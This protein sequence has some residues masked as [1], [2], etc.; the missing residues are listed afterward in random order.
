MRLVVFGLT[1]SSSWGNGHA[2]LWR[3]LARALARA[4]HHLEFF[5]RDE[6]WYAAHRDLA[7]LPGGTL[8]LYRDLDEVL[9]RARRALAGADAAMVT[10][11]CPDGARLGEEVAG[12]GARA[13][14]FY[15]L[16]TPVTR[17]R[18][19]DGDGIPW[20]GPGG[21]AA[22]D[23]VLSFTGG[24]SLA[25]LAEALGA[26]RAVPLH[27]WV[28]PEVHHPAPP[29]PAFAGDLSYLGTFAASRQ[30]G[31][32]ALFLGPAALLPRR[33]FVLAGALY[34]ERFP[35]RENVRWVRHLA[36]ARHPAFFCSSPLTLSVTRAE[37]AEDGYCPSGRLFEAAACGVPVLTDPWP[38]LEAFFAPGD[39]ILVARTAAEAAAA[40][41]TSRGEL[42]RIG[43]RARARA[44]AEHTAEARAAELVRILEGA[45]GRAG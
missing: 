42:A 17:A 25:F 37:M 23:V 35:W 32:E 40:V 7:E 12:S 11:F 8:H 39:E 16:D 36:P 30:E 10:S 38:G 9:P 44:L 14:A 18:L 28:D 19:R 22:Y 1:V 20:L 21:L 24:A 15:D 27:G 5:E 33:T 4:G 34:D 2:T 43:A 3:G 31:V 13:K 6:P 29:D 41:E 45:P 26:R